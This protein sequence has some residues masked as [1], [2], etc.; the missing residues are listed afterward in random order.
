MIRITNSR[1]LLFIPITNRREFVL[2]EYQY[3]WLFS[4]ADR[5]L[6]LLRVRNADISPVRNE[7]YKVNIIL[8]P[9]VR[10][11]E[12][13]YFLTSLRPCHFPVVVSALQYLEG[14]IFTSSSCM[15]IIN[16]KSIIF[17]PN[18]YHKSV[19]HAKEIHNIA[20]GVI[21]SGLLNISI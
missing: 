21:S 11:G 15:P 16:E 2:R 10:N 18:E 8:P 6:Y 12:Y 20:D 1:Q 5:I 4:T 3:L 13:E 19:F 17:A 9:E 14:D 7:T